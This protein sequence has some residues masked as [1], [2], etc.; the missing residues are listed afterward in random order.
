[1]SCFK[2]I[3]AVLTKRH[4]LEYN[5]R[6]DWSK[7][8]IWILFCNKLYNK[9]RWTMTWVCV[10]LIYEY[11]KSVHSVFGI[12]WILSTKWK[13]HNCKSILIYFSKK[14]F[15]ENLTYFFQTPFPHFFTT[16]SSD[17]AIKVPQFIS[18]FLWA[19]IL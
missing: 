6:F 18:K 4:Q 16:I 17:Q 5:N 2:Q 8:M 9:F 1:M 13:R 10:F 7:H 11:E 19:N 15:C 12:G 14:F 3:A